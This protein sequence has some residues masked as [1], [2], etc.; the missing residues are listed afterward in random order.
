MIN[1]TSWWAERR[2]SALHLLR[3]DQARRAY[4]LVSGVRPEDINRSKEQAFFAGWLALQRLVEPDK[5]LD[6]FSRMLTQADG[7]LSASTA[8]YWLGR[9]HEK[10]GDQR[11]AQQQYQAGAKIRDTFHGLLAKRRI[12]PRSRAIKLPPTRPP[13]PADVEAVLNS[14]AV[15]ALVLSHRLNLSRRKIL[16]F[17]RSLGRN[18]P[19][20]GQLALVAALASE[21]GDHQGEV[22]IGKYA[23]ARGFNLYEF[24]YPLHVLPDYKP[25]REPPERAMIYAIAPPGKRVQYQNCIARRR[26]RYPSGD[27]NHGQTHLSP[28]QNQ[29]QHFTSAYRPTL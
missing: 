15:R 9:T 13:S 7:P 22:R 17:Y 25:L 5:A 28:I 14:D 16:G 12:A 6:H 11:A 23:I 1:R 4:A 18:L 8:R 19:T 3:A 26:T 24:A 10:L 29:M 2:A 20:A 21:L 27:A